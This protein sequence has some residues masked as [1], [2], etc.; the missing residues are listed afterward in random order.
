M[1]QSDL[2]CV[3][4]YGDDNSREWH[5]GETIEKTREQ[6]PLGFLLNFRPNNRKIHLVL[7]YLRTRALWTGKITNSSNLNDLIKNENKFKFGVY[8]EL[9]DDFDLKRPIQN[10]PIPSDPLVFLMQKNA[11]RYLNFVFHL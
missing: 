8:E 9:F 6:I 1:N 3:T 2:D 5:I 7:F 11:S 4:F 10:V